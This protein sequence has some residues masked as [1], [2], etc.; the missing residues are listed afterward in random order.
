MSAPPQQYDTQ[1]IVQGFMVKQGGMHKSWKKRWFCNSLEDPFTLCY[2]T[3]ETCNVKKGAIDLREV[4]HFRTKFDTKERGPKQRVG[5]ALVTPS[6]T[7]KLIATGSTN[8]DYWTQGLERLIHRARRM[9]NGGGGS[10]PKLAAQ[11]TPTA[12][13]PAGPATVTSVSAPVV[14]AAPLATTGPTMVPAPTPLVAPVSVARPAATAGGGTESPTLS[15]PVEADS[16]KPVDA[17]KAR[18]T[19][20]ALFAYTA[21]NSNELSFQKGDKLTILQRDD[22][23][24]W[25][26]AELNGRRGWVS[27]FY[28]ALDP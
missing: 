12:T 15:R 7:W 3:D 19:A 16:S 2:Y 13:T 4:Y 17:S 26:A 25:W 5:L 1:L 18:P 11:P 21:A 23:A 10:S 6:R 24:G 14:A 9:G 8:G 20:T 27:S 28:V 22:E